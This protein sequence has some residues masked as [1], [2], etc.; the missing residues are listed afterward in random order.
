[1]LIFYLDQVQTPLCGNDTCNVPQS[2]QMQGIL[3]VPQWPLAAKNL[4]F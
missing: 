3:M 1:M 2:A 4:L